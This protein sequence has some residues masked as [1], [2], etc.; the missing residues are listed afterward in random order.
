MIPDKRPKLGRGGGGIRLGDGAKR[1]VRGE[2][3]TGRTKV[4][5][6]KFRVP[7]AGGAPRVGGRV[8][9]NASHEDRAETR[10]TNP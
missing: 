8:A 2:V 7:T 1:L 4:W 6:L 5:R 10:A 3:S 9:L